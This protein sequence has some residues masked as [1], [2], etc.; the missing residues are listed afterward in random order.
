MADTAQD[1]TRSD[2]SEIPLR[3]AGAGLS[4]ST[5]ETHLLACGYGKTDVE[6]FARRFR[7][8][9][10]VWREFERLTLR[11]VS[12]RKRAGAI[13]ILGR[14]RWE[15]QIEQRLEFKCNNTDAPYLARVFALK[16]PQ[17]A[18]FFEFRSVG[19]DQK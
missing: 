1:T 17:Y 5:V 8:A 6:G 18:S 12:E 9:P 3:S 13:D 15:R 16:Y 11:L 14:V 4:L 19:G 10:E 7:A 2:F